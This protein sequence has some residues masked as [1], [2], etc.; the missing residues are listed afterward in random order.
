[1][2]FSVCRL[3]IRIIKKNR[4]NSNIIC[5]QNAVALQN[6]NSSSIYALLGESSGSESF[7]V[8]KGDLRPHLQTIK[9]KACL[10]FVLCTALSLSAFVNH[11]PFFHLFH[12]VL[13]SFIE[14]M[15]F[16]GRLSFNSTSRH[17]SDCLPFW[18]VF[19][20]NF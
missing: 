11:S 3:Y 8:T 2:K 12:S 13:V 19:H 1:M 4:K 15:N 9:Y 10:L 7:E 6:L 5:Q 17:F 16:I 20:D 14:R 18:V